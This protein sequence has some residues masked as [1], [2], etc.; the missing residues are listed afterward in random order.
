MALTCLVLLPAAAPDPAREL[1]LRETKVRRSEAR[2]R[3]AGVMG[4]RLPR[5]Q[6]RRHAH[7]ARHDRAGRRPECSDDV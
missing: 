5:R 1:A 7:H 4:R 6:L 3:A 2:R